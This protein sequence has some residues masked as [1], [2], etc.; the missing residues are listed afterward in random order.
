MEGGRKAPQKPIAAVLVAVALAGC[1]VAPP[2]SA[3]DYANAAALRA[4]DGTLT[5]VVGP[6]TA[7]VTM[8]STVKFPEG[9]T[10]SRVR[11]VL[12]Y[13]APSDQ[14][15]FCLFQIG[16]A[17]RSAPI[18]KED[19]VQRPC[20]GKRWARFR[21]AG[22]DIG[23]VAHLVHT[24]YKGIPVILLEIADHQVPDSIRLLY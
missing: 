12:T 5:T 16:H 21:I 2:H 23:F 19:A 15:G 9:D 14:P 20:D 13:E 7:I 8:T 10:S 6:D 4:P 18:I 3:K 1:V 22:T 11:S 17:A 24:N